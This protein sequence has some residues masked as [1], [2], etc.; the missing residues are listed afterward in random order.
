MTDANFK[1]KDIQTI[2]GWVLRSGVIV[3]MVVVFTGGMIY[4]SRHGN[5]VIDYTQ[6]KGVPDFLHTPG[7]IIKGIADLR[8]RAI[9]QAGIILL[10]ATPVIRIIFS[11]VGF[12]ME[13]DHLYTV[14]TCMVL[15]VILIGM[16][17]GH[18]G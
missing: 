6:F 11:V 8:G 10:I 5:E 4:L 7:G 15:L 9:I 16:F 17:T 3:S 18:A 13:K 12:V 14:I 2:I 1:D